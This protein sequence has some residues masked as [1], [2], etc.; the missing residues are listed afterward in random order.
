MVRVYALCT[1]EKSTTRSQFLYRD[2]SQDLCT[3]AFYF[4]LVIG[5]DGPVVID[6]SVDEGEAKRRG[7]YGYRERVELLRACGVSPADVKTV[8][9]THLHY[10]HW[11]GHGLFTN[12]VF[13]VQARELAFWQ[14]D[15]R[16][17]AMFSASADVA[18]LDCLHTLERDGRI[19]VV[20][21]D[22]SL[23]AGMQANL[24]GGHTPGLQ[25]LSVATQ[26]G[27]VLLASDA[28]HFYEGLA[29]RKPVQ[30]T[31]NMREA[32]HAMD[33]V[34][35]LSRDHPQLALPGH[36]ADVMRRFPTVAPGVVRIA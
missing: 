15:G 16:R 27:N 25:T 7:I 29:A 30:V 18:A 33:R 14:G 11:S 5:P 24:L 17:Y 13:A 6:C 12:A 28:F 3:I 21:G 32:L 36:D 2:G 20:D 34:A 23:G 4:W 35:E 26:H 31:V 8:F 10:D 9:M 1:G 22:W 19:R